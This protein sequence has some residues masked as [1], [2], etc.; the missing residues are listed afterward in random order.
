MKF[1]VIS[2]FVKADQ[3]HTTLHDKYIYIFHYGYFSSPTTSIYYIISFY[4][5][6][7]FTTTIC[8]LLIVSKCK[9]LDITTLFSCLLSVVTRRL[10]W[11]VVTE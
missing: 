11:L 2:R 9:K 5:I 6:V 1:V 4:V 10:Q 7:V 3:N 8:I